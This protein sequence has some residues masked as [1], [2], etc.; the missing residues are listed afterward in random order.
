MILLALDLGPHAAF[1]WWSYLLVAAVIGGLVAW[2]IADGRR[3]QRQLDALD[4]RG[5]R[6]RSA[7]HDR[8]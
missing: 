6:R 8:A 4:A 3:T 1:I 2:L 7:D 5:I